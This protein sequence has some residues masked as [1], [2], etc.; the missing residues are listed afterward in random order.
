MQLYL[1]PEPEAPAPAPPAADLADRL[2]ALGLPPF[3]EVR[4]HRNQQVMLSW[5]PGVR[6]RIHAGYAEA[7]DEVLRAIVRFVTPGSR[8][9]IRLNARRLFLAFPADQHAPAPERHPRVA[10]AGDQRVLERL[11]RLHAELNHWHFGG[12]LRPIVLRTSSRMRRRLGELRLERRTGRAVCIILSRRHLRRDG[13]A[14]ASET[15]LHEMIHQ[16]QAET[17]R[18][19]DHG[20]EFRRKAR[21]L[22]IEPR[23]VSRRGT[24]Y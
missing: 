10:P 1:W 13:W 22:G 21:E 4:T 5:T 18:P 23:A 11:R 9:E 6:L 17:G 15:L 14:A 19:V 7:P 12:T 2:R 3:G 8:R 16:W 24:E 20:S